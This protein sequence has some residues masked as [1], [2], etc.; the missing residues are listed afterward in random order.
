MKR[1]QPLRRALERAAR[2]V[3]ANA[4]STAQS[5]GID[6]EKIDRFKTIVRRK[7]RALLCRIFTPRELRY[8]LAKARPWQHL[9]ARFAAK[10]A[11]IKALSCNHKFSNYRHIEIVNRKDGA[12][13]VKL[14]IK[15]RLKVK[16]SISL[17]HAE[18]YAAAVALARWV[19][20]VRQGNAVQPI[21]P[22]II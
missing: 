13:A 10:E 1:K 17:T 2:S 11:I 5:I 22:I 21:R 12:P 15:P 16:L 14:S 6:L 20:H 9:A 3:Q 4:T 18:G 7:D 19:S 8:C